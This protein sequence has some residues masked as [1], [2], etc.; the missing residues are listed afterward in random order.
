MDTGS[1]LPP[2]AT[3]FAMDLAT[4]IMAITQNMIKSRKQEI[5]AEKATISENEAMMLK[6]MDFETVQGLSD[7]IQEDH[8]QAVQDM[9]D[10]YAE[11]YKQYDGKFPTTVILE[12]KRDQREMETDIANKKA[13]VLAYAELWKKLQD[14]KAND[15]MDV[16][17]TAANMAKW[18]QDGNIGKSTLGLMKLRDWTG[19]QIVMADDGKMLDDIS[20]R[21]NEKMA[22]AKPGEKEQIIETFGKEA[23]DAAKIILANKRLNTPDKIADAQ[24]L[25]DIRLRDITKEKYIRANQPRSGGKQTDP[26]DYIDANKVMQATLYGDSGSLDNYVN[27]IGGSSRSNP[28]WVKDPTTGRMKGSV[29]IFMPNGDQKRIP[30]LDANSSEEEV[31]A[32]KL[33]YNSML[34]PIYQVKKP[35]NIKT[36]QPLIDPVKIDAP[37]ENANIANLLSKDNRKKEMPSVDEKG[38][39]MKPTDPG[40]ESKPGYKRAIDALSA[41]LDPA[42]YEVRKTSVIWGD[43]GKGSNN[44]EII[45]KT[46]PSNP[47]SHVFD[48]TKPE[49]VKALLKFHKENSISETNYKNAIELKDGKKAEPTPNTAPK[50]KEVDPLGIL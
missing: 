14:P 3:P 1:G 29:T 32:A 17:T 2:T 48:W 39:P 21:F 44:I 15:Y 20:K 49:D 31:R 34:A 12:M 35:T 26:N 11:K 18:A 28:A 37:L 8:V 38:N 46:N 24:K 16:E 43:M 30:V 25:V 6:A 36:E 33:A 5:A 19:A 41:D 40:Y 23:A 47:V 4:P 45:D 22:Y 42:K 9:T 7:K 50:P 10:K 13:N 27:K